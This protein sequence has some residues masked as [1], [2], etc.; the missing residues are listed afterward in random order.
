MAKPRKRSD[1]ERRARQCERLSRV[2][3]ILRCIM[4]PG[5]WDAAGLAREL[6]CSSRTIHR[7]LQTLSMA[8]V[9]WYFDN[10]RQAYRV[11]AGF[12]FP[13]IEPESTPLTNEP[14]QLLR[15]T[16]RVLDDIESLASTLR[17]YLAILEGEKPSAGPQPSKT[18][19]RPT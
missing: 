9:P 5:R 6:E 2:L 8:G 11:Q 16:K 7:N 13:S 19:P 14:A 10:D 15:R 4:G 12:R 1:A 3:R 17:D 18:G